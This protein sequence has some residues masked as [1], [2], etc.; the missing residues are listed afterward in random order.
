M[1]TSISDI[2]DDNGEYT[3]ELEVNNIDNKDY[4]SE[5]IAQLIMTS[6]QTI[7]EYAQGMPTKD[8]YEFDEDGCLSIKEMNSCLG[9]FKK[10]HLDKFTKLLKEN[11]QSIEFSD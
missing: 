10:N 3:L 11:V 7:V 8:N 2:L 5:V 9:K 6:I 4:R 1:Q